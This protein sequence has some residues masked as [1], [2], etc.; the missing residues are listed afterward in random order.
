M[1]ELKKSITKYKSKLKTELGDDRHSCRIYK[2]IVCYEFYRE[3]SNRDI[4]L[5]TYMNNLD[6]DGLDTLYNRLR[7]NSDV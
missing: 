4:S 6:E 3:S 2:Y 1:A 7:D 5:S